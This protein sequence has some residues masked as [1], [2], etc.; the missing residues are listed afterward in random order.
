MGER[1]MLPMQI[2]STAIFFELA[3]PIYLLF[4]NT[5]DTA[6][7]NRFSATQIEI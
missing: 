3:T 1:Q 6:L 2:K 5:H 7:Q 4:E